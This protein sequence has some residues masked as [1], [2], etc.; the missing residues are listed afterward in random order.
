MAALALCATGAVGLAPVAVAEPAEAPLL[1]TPGMSVSLAQAGELRLWGDNTYGQATVPASLAGVAISQVVLPDRA[2]IALT[3][4]GRVVG[5]GRHAIEPVERVPSVVAAAKVAQ[6][7]AQ[8]TY[9]GAVT[10]DGR[11]LMWGQ[12]LATPTPLDVP[13]GLSGVKQLALAEFTAAALKADGSVVG[14]GSPVSG[15]TQVPEG[16]RATAIAST[17]TGFLALTD[18]GTV[19]T[20]GSWTWPG[21]VK[22][23][24]L[25]V[26]GNVK[27]IAASR[28]GAMALLADGTLFFFGMPL[29][30]EVPAEFTT[31]R[32]VLLANSLGPAE[33]AIVDEDRTIRYWAAGT[34]SEVVPVELGG[35]DLAQIVLGWAEAMGGGTSQK[36]G[37]AIVTK[38]LR[39]ELPKVSGTA[40]VGSVLTGVP[41]TFSAEPDLVTSQWLV[42]G[43]P[44][45]GGSAQL[46]VTSAMV[47]KRISYRSTASKVGQTTVASTSVPVTVTKPPAPVVPS[48]TRVTKVK[49]A[50]KGATVAVTGKVTASK[51]P[52]GRAKVTIKKGKTTIVAKN[53]KVA[54]KGAVKLNVKKFAKLVAKKTKAKGKKAQTAYRGK[55]TVTIAY[56]GA[57]QV[58]PSKAAKAFKI[59]R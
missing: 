7:A 13:V 5:W 24:A 43:A 9:A 32:P 18:Q 42:G 47:G 57:A 12:K 17:G 6:I 52:T 48:K 54:A 59:K 15:R 31:A 29:G 56:A 40:R 3:A 44:V 30:Y 46:T 53:V 36:T 25:Q 8:G 22:P 45:A 39:A 26:P 49:V 14:W 2:V 35:S 27:A 21:A 58:R 28:R 19:E 34:P 16:L 38:L 4:D 51:A 1:S 23:A 33:F 55:Y 11:V 37:A 50:K 10:R 41:G 20:W